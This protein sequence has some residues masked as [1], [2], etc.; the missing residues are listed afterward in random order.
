MGKSQTFILLLVIFL[1]GCGGGGSGDSDSGNSEGAPS[2]I[3]PLIT[4]HEFQAKIPQIGNNWCDSDDLEQMI[5]HCPDHLVDISDQ[6]LIGGRSYF[7][8]IDLDNPSGNI[9]ALNIEAL[10]DNDLWL[11]E[12]IE[13]DPNYK[14]GPGDPSTLWIVFELSNEIQCYIHDVD[15]WLETTD[16]R[17]SDVYSFEVYIEDFCYPAGP[18]PPPTP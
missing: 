16:G 17:N 4:G 15:M 12:K 9:K 2:T 10:R 14:Q 11:S 8:A 7:L 3:I 6:R 1:A 5:E 13:I 18:P